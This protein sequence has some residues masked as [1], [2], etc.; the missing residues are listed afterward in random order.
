MTRMI[1]LHQAANN[2]VV[3]RAELLR[4][5]GRF[6]D[7]IRLLTSGAPETKIPGNESVV[8]PQVG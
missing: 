7:A 8:S 1:E 3:E 5:L 6:D 2:G 4:Q